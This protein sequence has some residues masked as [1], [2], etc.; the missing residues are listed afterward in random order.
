[1]GKQFFFMAKTRAD[2]QK[3]HRERKKAKE[4]SAYLNHEVKIQDA[5]DFNDWARKNENSSSVSYSRVLLKRRVLWRRQNSL[6]ENTKMSKPF[7]TQW[8][9][10]LLPAFR[11]SKLKWKKR[12]VT[13]TNAWRVK[14]SKEVQHV[15]EV[16]VMKLQVLLTADLL[17]VSTI[18]LLPTMKVPGTLDKSTGWRGRGFLHD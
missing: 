8:K 7:K 5:V 1:M 10:T 6:I 9:F 16:T 11:R 13:V 15:V 14:N 17:F 3:A 18:G 2:I 12:P 4:G